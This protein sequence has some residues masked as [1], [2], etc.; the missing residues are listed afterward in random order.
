M[1]LLVV[2]FNIE[3]AHSIMRA[4]FEKFSNKN[5]SLPSLLSVCPWQGKKCAKARQIFLATKKC[6]SAKRIRSNRAKIVAT[7]GKSNI[8]RPQ[9]LEQTSVVVSYFGFG[10]CITYSVVMCKKLWPTRKTSDCDWGMRM[11]YYLVGEF[12]G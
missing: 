6:K 7:T 3:H 5:P 12:L 1:I 10:Q 8:S 11:R 2:I 9:Y 4:K